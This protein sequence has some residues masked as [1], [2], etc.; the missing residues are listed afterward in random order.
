MTEEDT[1]SATQLM[2]KLN[3]EKGSHSSAE[4]YVP[5]YEPF[6]QEHYSDLPI[7]FRLIPLAVIVR[8]AGA[9]ESANVTSAYIDQYL[10]QQPMYAPA[11]PPAPSAWTL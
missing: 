7:L 2:S 9:Q 11:Y 8:P 5:D 3:L 10:K 1:K 6:I 4:P